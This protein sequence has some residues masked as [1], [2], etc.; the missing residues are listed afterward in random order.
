MP[1]A[2]LPD[3][4]FSGTV[5]P[6]LEMANITISFPGVKALSGVDFRM[7]RGEVHALMGQNTRK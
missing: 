7:F 5:P 6:V 1:D 3:A 4:D 2:R